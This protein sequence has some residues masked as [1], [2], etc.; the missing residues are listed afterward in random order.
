MFV[1]LEGI[2]GLVAKEIVVVCQCESEKLKFSIKQV[3]KISTAKVDILSII[4][5]LS[6]KEMTAQ[7]KH[8][9]FVVLV[10]VQQPCRLNTVEITNSYSSHSLITLASRNEILPYLLTFEVKLLLA[11]LFCMI[12]SCNGV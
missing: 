10:K 2:K 11:D 8:V 7:R 1:F 9:L 12:V 4:L 5:V 6:T 3:D